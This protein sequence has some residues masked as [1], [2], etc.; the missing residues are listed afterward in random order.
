MKKVVISV[1]FLSFFLI[2]SCS[3]ESKR[4]T[5]ALTKYENDNSKENLVMVIRIAM[6]DGNGPIALKYAKQ[7]YDS[8]PDNIEYKCL[9]AASLGVYAGY[10]KKQNE[11]V[12]YGSY[13]NNLLNEA[14]MDEP[15]N[16]IPYSYRA[17]AGIN[18]P[19]WL[20]FYKKS[21]TDFEKIFELA[22]EG[23][24]PDNRREYTLKMAYNGYIKALTLDDQEDKID[25]ATKMF[26][27]NFSDIEI[28]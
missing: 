12:E 14:V 27:S 24:I 9:Y 17:Q 22:I 1:L 25:E 21:I 18:S 7:M 23:K 4:L 16:Y 28:N 20:E 26:Q 13:S 5:E 2:L 19:E 3:S 10:T 6:G 11:K 15:E 8:E